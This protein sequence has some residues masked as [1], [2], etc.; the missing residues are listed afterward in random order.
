M[1]ASSSVAV[2][3]PSSSNALFFPSAFEDPAVFELLTMPTFVS[4]VLAATCEIR[5]RLKTQRDVHTW[6]KCLDG[7]FL[8]LLCGGQLRKENR[9]FKQKA[10]IRRRSTFSTSFKN[11]DLGGGRAEGVSGNPIRLFVFDRVMS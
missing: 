1:G 11:F 3:S 8:I 9:P 5:P 7:I 2:A 4:L 6:M 10:L